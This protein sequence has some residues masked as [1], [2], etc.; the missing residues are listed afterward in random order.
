[1]N[2]TGETKIF[3]GIILATVV[4]I[5]G[6]IFLFNKPAPSFTREDMVPSGITTFG[7]R[8]AKVYLVE[9][10]DFQCPAC[11]AF[12]PFVDELKTSYKDKL[13][14]VYR[15]F[16]LQQHQ[17]AKQS[18][19]AAE[20]AGEQGKFWEMY[21]FL[22]TNQEKLSEEKIA[23]GVKTLGLDQKKYDEAVKSEKVKSKIEKDL[24][25]GQRF[26][27]TGTPTFYLNG[28]KLELASFSDLK[29]AVDEAL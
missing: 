9:F 6:G 7:F 23:E 18:A 29:R 27:V 16:P 1:M 17:F 20:A 28:Q 15:H 8:D 5:M 10:S 25:D 4:I 11:G 14:F 24:S 26:G 22:F 21:D 2:I 13:L 3:L 12:K 19:F